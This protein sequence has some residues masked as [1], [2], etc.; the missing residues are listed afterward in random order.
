MEIFCFA[1]PERLFLLSLLVPLAG[2]LVWGMWRK[3]RARKLLADRK[4]SESLLGKWSPYREIVIRVMQFFATGFLL[5]AWCGPQLCTGDKLVRREAVDVVYVL[6]V[7][8]SMLARDEVPDRLGKAK[9]EMLV[10]SRGIDRG[11]RALVAFAGSAVVQCPLTADQ[12]A[13]EAMLAIASPGLVEEQGTNLEAA[14][15]IAGRVL[16]GR[17]NS[18]NAAGLRIVVI[19]SDGENHDK[20]F[21][22]TVRRLSEMGIQ[23]FVV[24]VGTPDPVPIPLQDD[25]GLSG[26]VRRDAEGSPVLTSFRPEVLSKLVEEAGGIFLHSRENEPVS[27]RVQE[28]LGAV[29]N[30]MQWMREPRYREEVY[31]YF[32]LVSVLLLLGAGVVASR[33]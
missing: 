7:S 32:V 3:A 13:F 11:R 31:H 20:T 33:S 9:Q 10:I 15:D 18:R 14:L 19:A 26:S 28:A 25:E 23:L 27:G 6:D 1:Y 29:K 2:V 16:T 17:G 21:T 24:G 30:K 22:G 12:R 5:V 4:L 8:N